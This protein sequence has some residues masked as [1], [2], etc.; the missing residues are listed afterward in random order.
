[1][2][3]AM[4]APLLSSATLFVSVAAEAHISALPA[5][6][7]L[8]EHVVVTLAIGM[9]LGAIVTVARRRSKR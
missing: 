5:T 8:A 9:V 2:K 1:M 4:F 3:H 6:T 7:H